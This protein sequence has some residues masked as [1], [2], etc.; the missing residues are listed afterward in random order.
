M[1]HPCKTGNPGITM[2]ACSTVNAATTLCGLQ[3][4]PGTIGV[5]EGYRKLCPHCFPMELAPDTRLADLEI[6]GRNPS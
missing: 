6:Q 1:T 3:V 5:V 4:E 2:H